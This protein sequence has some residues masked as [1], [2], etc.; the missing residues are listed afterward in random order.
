MNEAADLGYGFEVGPIR[1]PNEA[2]SL[3]VRVTR[4]CPYNRCAFCPVYKG[5]RFSLRSVDEVLTDIRAM[6]RT[7]QRFHDRA[8]ASGG[9]SRQV[10]G[11][12]LRELSSPGA[13]QVAQFLAVGGKT[14]FLQDANSLIMPVDQLVQVLDALRRAFPSLRRVTSYARAH[15][16]TKRS[17]AELRR[18]RE[19]GLDRVHIGLESGSD[20]VLELVAKGATAERHI[21]A[22][23]RVKQAGLELSE[24]VMPGLGGRALS[25]EHATET[26]RVLRAIDPHYV[27]LR[28]LAISPG[29]PLDE[30]VCRGE[31][32]PASDVEVA[33]ELGLLLRGFE[34]MTGTITSDHILNLLEE[35][36]GKLPDD[37]PRMLDA[38]ERF[39]ALD[40]GQRDIYVVG[41][42]LGL[43]RRLDDL[44]D[45]P[46]RKQAELALEQVRRRFPG[47]LDQAIREMMTRF[48]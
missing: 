29:T 2:N 19:A 14:A 33:R 32:E 1:P 10:L 15:T 8:A 18:L 13:V 30:M 23:L 24:Y 17:V 7:A 48:V 12:V 34:G 31:L 6:E 26:A 28:T 11:E 40:E 3:L 16:V 44:D 46:Y 27:R 36:T 9:L 42:R 39:L 22:G 5:T 47:P 38:V 35:V 45:P 43:L 4:N 20:R 25:R 21:A 37:L 41:R